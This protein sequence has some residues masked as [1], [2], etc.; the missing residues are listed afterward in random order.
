MKNF[1]FYESSSFNVI[2]VS[3]SQKYVD[4]RQILQQKRFKC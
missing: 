2:F 4:K 1:L 3:K